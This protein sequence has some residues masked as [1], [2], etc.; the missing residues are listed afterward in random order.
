MLDPAIIRKNPDAVREGV[1]K[2]NVSPLLIDEFLAIDEKWR[3]ISGE[4]DAARGNQNKLSDSLAKEK[5]EANL[6]RAREL[7]EKAA[8]LEAERGELEKKRDEILNC[9]PNVPFDDAPTG[10]DE[11]ENLV[12]KEVGEKPVRDF[13]VKDYLA[14]AENLGLIDVKKSGEVSGSRFGYLLGEAALLELAL[15]HLAF[16]TLVSEGFMPAIP[17]VMIKPEVY[18]GMGRLAADQKE[19]RYY[20]EK[21]NLYLV[22]SSEHTMGPFHMNDVLDYKTLPRRYVAFSTCFRREA[23]SHGKDTKGILRVHQFDKVEMFSFTEPEKS[24]EEHKFLLSMQENLIQKLKL[25]YR[26]VSICA[27][28]M[29]WTDARQYDIE[30]WLPGQTGADGKKGIY[31]ET[32]S[33]SNTTDF[34]ARGINARYRGRDGRPEYLHMLNATGFAI[35]RILI[36]IIENYQQA[37][38][39]IAVPEALQEYMGKKLIRPA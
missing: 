28:D 39:S 21:D 30:V 33:C 31:R 37:D 35:G 13:E 11:G 27:G 18:A 32:N 25:P 5:N 34:Q 6:I 17:P 1:K 3:K 24:E 29:G 19:E 4:L 20:L 26:V 36:A 9:L 10:K 38:G 23:G 22:G 15:V 16:E 2:K 14:I 12:L 7:K 8:I